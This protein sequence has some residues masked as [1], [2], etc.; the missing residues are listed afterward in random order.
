MRRRLAHESELF[1]P[2]DRSRRT[3][4]RRA[5]AVVLF[6]VAIVGGA[7]LE[8]RQPTS[9]PLTSGPVTYVFHPLLRGEELTVGTATVW[10]EGTHDAQIVSIQP[11]G[12]MKVRVL[13]FRIMDDGPTAPATAVSFPPRGAVPLH[14]YR[15][16][17]VD[18]SLTN[19]NYARIMVGLTVDPGERGHIQGLEVVYQAGSSRYQ[20]Y[21]HHEMT[22]CGYDAV[23]GDCDLDKGP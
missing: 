8:R 4:R 10:N 12:A 11:R 20:T 5:V 6:V 9:G 7:A 15:I 21:L 2:T 19:R 3:G 1:T 14:Q 22:I 18:M 17:P 16:R 23:R 13:G